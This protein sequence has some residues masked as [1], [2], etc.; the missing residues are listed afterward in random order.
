MPQQLWF[1]QIPDIQKPG[2]PCVW[3]GLFD[4]AKYL[5][6][7]Q[8]HQHSFIQAAE[9]CRRDSM[10]TDC[11]WLNI[12]NVDIYLIDDFVVSLLFKE[13]HFEV[14]APHDVASEQVVHVSFTWVSVNRECRSIRIQEFLCCFVQIIAMLYLLFML[15]V[16]A[17]SV[18][19]EFVILLLNFLTFSSLLIRCF[20]WV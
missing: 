13:I 11:P 7:R 3:V 16:S 6:H 2:T 9:N 8:P 1:S 10:S 4:H 12:T 18:A 14:L 19:F 20:E 15:I 5:F 17:F